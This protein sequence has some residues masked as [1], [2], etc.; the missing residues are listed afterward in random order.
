MGNKKAHISVPH[1]YVTLKIG[2]LQQQTKTTHKTTTTTKPN[3]PPLPQKTNQS[4]KQ[5]T[6]F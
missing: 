1:H 6:Y 5:T 2:Q 3:Q 4:N